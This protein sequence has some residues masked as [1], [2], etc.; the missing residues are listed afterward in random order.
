[1]L[2]LILRL[3]LKFISCSYLEQQFTSFT[4][5]PFGHF[6]K[7]LQ[8]TFSRICNTTSFFTTQ[9]I[10]FYRTLKA[11]LTIQYQTMQL[12]KLNIT[13]LIYYDMISHCPKD[14]VHYLFRHCHKFDGQW[15]EKKF[16]WH[17]RC[18]PRKISEKFIQI[19]YCL[20]QKQKKPYYFEGRFECFEQDFA[21]KSN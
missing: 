4:V 13:L 5:S 7:K 16:I 17:S 1:M 19:W 18:W 21:E 15:N 14:K 8:M 10:F 20:A 11:V 2:K 12:V 9:Q 6:P 3:W